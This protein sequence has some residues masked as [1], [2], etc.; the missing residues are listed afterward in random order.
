MRLRS[1]YRTAGLVSPDPTA[2][3][4]NVKRYEVIARLAIRKLLVNNFVRQSKKVA[5]KLIAANICRNE[6]TCLLFFAWNFA[7]LDV[8]RSDSP[9]E[10][11]VE[12]A[13]FCL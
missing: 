2:K 7:N 10:V 5:K 4:E 9:P 6:N 13:G 3:M 11:H 1:A 8:N 12:T